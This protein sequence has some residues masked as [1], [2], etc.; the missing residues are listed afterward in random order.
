MRRERKGRTGVREE[1]KAVSPAPKSTPLRPEQPKQEPK[2]PEEGR[3]ARA[4]KKV[5]ARLRKLHPMD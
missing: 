4:R 3:E 1:A 5:I 2:E